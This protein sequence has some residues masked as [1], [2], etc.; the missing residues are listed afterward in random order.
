MKKTLFIIVMLMHIF[1]V[2]AAGKLGDKKTF[3]IP[4][5]VY[6]DLASNKP[7]PASP[8][9]P[10]KPTK[11]EAPTKAQFTTGNGTFLTDEYNKKLEEYNQSS[12]KIGYDNAMNT[13]TTDMEKYKEL[14][15]IY[16][17]ALDQWEAVNAKAYASLKLFLKQ[18]RDKHRGAS[19]V[20]TKLGHTTLEYTTLIANISDKPV[21]V[22]FKEG[23]MDAT[24][25]GLITAGALLIAAGAAAEVATA[26]AATGGLIAAAGAGTA[27]VATGAHNANYNKKQH[28][29]SKTDWETINPNE[30]KIFHRLKSAAKARFVVVPKKTSC[31]DKDVKGLQ[32]KVGDNNGIVVITTVNDCGITGYDQLI[33]REIRNQKKQEK[34][35]TKTDKEITSLRENFCKASGGTN[36]MK[37]ANKLKKLGASVPKPQECQQLLQQQK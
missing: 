27:L 15:A 8:V 12:E 34:H 32:A 17:K 13:Y 6:K 28:A 33:P 23:D 9:E 14:D 22:I 24:D 16:Q 2:N 4:S 11:P 35:D 7:A 31:N 10:V 30:A 19:D 20:K 29:T 25:I 3:E 5:S 26:G 1:D 36:R 21:K 18:L 37:I